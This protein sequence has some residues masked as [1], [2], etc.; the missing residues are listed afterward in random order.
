MMAACAAAS[1]TGRVFSVRAHAGCDHA[2][3]SS[4]TGARKVPG[5]PG[6][7]RTASQSQQPPAAAAAAAAVD[8]DQAQIETFLDG[9]KYDDKGL[10]VAIAQDVDTGAILMQGFADRTAVRTTLTARKATFFSRSRQQQWTKGETSGNFISVKSVHIDCDRDSLV[11]L[12]IPDGPTCHTGAHTCYYSQVDGEKGAAFVAG[13]GFSGQEEA[14]TTLYELEATIK[15]RRTEVIVEGAKP[16]WT[17]RLL[18]NPTL[19]CEK[20]REEAGELCE[21]LEKGEGAEAAASEMADV[22]YHSMVLLNLH[23]VG[24]E[25]VLAVLR[26]RFGTS[27]VDEKAARP[28]KKQKE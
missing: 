18:D 1:A 25:D 23:G 20:V 21:T 17:R 13:G 8:A 16:S 28:P 26:N 14:M 10:V 3:S 9:L 4:T 6:A 22:L 7:R 24:M 19:L 5:V 11:Y 27:G 15:S 2:A 12:G